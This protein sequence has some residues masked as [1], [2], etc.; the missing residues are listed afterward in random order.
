MNERVRELHQTLAT[1]TNRFMIACE[2]ADTSC[3]ETIEILPHEYAAVRA[4]PRQF[5]VRPG[6]VYADVE[7]VIRETD[8]YVVVEKEGAAAE[9][10][11]RS[12]GR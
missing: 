2:C 1:V 12:A 6:H 10:A 4:D 7:S 3:I 5:A 8:R 9:V 11:E